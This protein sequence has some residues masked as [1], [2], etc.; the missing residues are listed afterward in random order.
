[1]PQHTDDY[2]RCEF[3]II[4]MFE[5]ETLEDALE[6]GAAITRLKLKTPAKLMDEEFIL[7]HLVRISMVL[8]PAHGTSFS[9]HAF[10]YFALTLILYKRRREE[11]AYRYRGSRRERASRENHSPAASR[12]HYYSRPLISPVPSAAITSFVMSRGGIKAQR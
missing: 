10:L 12:F 4:Y 1:M 6:N 11:F 2:R 8:S 9:R 7:F 3:T 5:F